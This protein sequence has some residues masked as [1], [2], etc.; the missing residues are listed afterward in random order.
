MIEIEL[1]VFGDLRRYR[2][3]MA[4]GEGQALSCDDGSTVKDILSQ[5]GIPDTEAKIILV[6]GRAKKVDD[7]L[8]DGDRLA[9]F[10]AVAGG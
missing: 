8:D 10:P 1:R 9:I 7:G 3:G 5:L 4:I 2:K 6:N